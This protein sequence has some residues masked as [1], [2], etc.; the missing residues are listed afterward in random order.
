MLNSKKQDR[1]SNFELLRIVA[2]LAIVFGHVAAQAFD[3]GILSTEI[4]SFLLLLGSGSRIGVNLFVMIGAWFMVDSTFK[5]DKVVK[6]YSSLWLYSVAITI[7]LLIAKCDISTM[8]VASSFFP[9]LRRRMWFVPQY[10]SL[11]LISPF[12]KILSCIMNKVTSCRFIIISFLLTSLICSIRT[13]ED[14]WLGGLTWFIFLYFVITH[15]KKY[16]FQ[17]KLSKEL[18]L[19]FGVTIYL[20]LTAGLIIFSLRDS[21]LFEMGYSV[22]K[23][24]LG[25]Y[26]SVPN[27]LC[28]LMIFMFFAELDMGK[29]KWINEISKN[30]LDVYM[31]HQHDAFIPIIWVGLFHTK[32]W[33]QSPFFILLYLG[34]VVT[35]YI[36]GSLIGRIR[37]CLIEP[38]WLKSRLFRRLCEI[39]DRFYEPLKELCEKY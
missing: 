12:L 4:N 38:M 7:I 11:L 36:C 18:N 39:I 9:F 25:D 3:R 31:I 35:V 37:M 1:N 20:A 8:N 2:M 32:E 33:Q 6:L 30:T 24:Y 10:I 28:S 27:F 17:F 15:Y 5:A 19:L 26:K 13:F 16:G 23:Q 14:T 29:N 34:T 21:R 22:F